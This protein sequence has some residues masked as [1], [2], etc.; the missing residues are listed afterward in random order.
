MM[1]QQSTRVHSCAAWRASCCCRRWR[2]GGGLASSCATSSPGT[3]SGRR[4]SFEQV[5][6]AQSGRR[7][8]RPAGSFAYARPGRS[9]G[10]YEK[11]YAQ[12]LVGDGKV[13]WPGIPTSTRSPCARSVE[14]LGATPAAILFGRQFALDDN[15]EL[16]TP[17]SAD[18]LAWIEARRSGTEDSGFES[19]RMGLPMASSR[20]MEMRDHFG[21][22]TVIRF[23][24]LRANPALAAGPLPLHAAQGRRRGRRIIA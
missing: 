14:A 21:Q 24:R 20:R 23:T 22:T 12:V 13:L 16:P 10:I 11:P 3:R 5:V 8:R 7:R 18:G 4:A 1:I 2:H 15:F 6:T 19:L 9:I 17:A